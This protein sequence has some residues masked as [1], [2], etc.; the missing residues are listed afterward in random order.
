[1][2]AD[3]IKIGAAIAVAYIGIVA[4]F[5]NLRAKRMLCAALG[6]VF[7]APVVLIA[8]CVILGINL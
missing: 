1:M 8:F 7:L 2:I 4:S 3:V 5:P 6:V